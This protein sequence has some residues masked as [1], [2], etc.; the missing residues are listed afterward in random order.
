MGRAFVFEA[1]FD[2]A[3]RAGWVA[4][5]ATDAELAESMEATLLMR[6]R[7]TGRF[8]ESRVLVE[9][10]NRFAVLFVGRQDARIE[11]FLVAGLSFPGRVAYRV[12]AEESDLGGESTLAGERER[13]KAW[14]GA[15]PGEPVQLFREVP[16][17][18][19][20][21]HAA[22]EW[23]LSKDGDDVDGAYPL[24]AEP[25][26][27]LIDAD[28][29]VGRI[30]AVDEA[31][32][33][34]AEKSMS[35]RFELKDDAKQRLADFGAAHAARRCVAVVD[36]RVVD[37]RD[38]SASFFAEPY[39]VRAGWTFDEARSKMMAI[40]GGRLDA[41]LTFV[42]FSKRELP[43]VKRRGAE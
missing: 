28:I 16:R 25:S 41:P 42:E 32:E 6:L 11:E 13:L 19:G 14:T 29:P 17:D 43:H 8:V 40:S 20:G 12:V 7:R 18:A 27:P 26:F 15:H 22:L 34:A 2:F 5:D 36:D 38:D 3:R 9:G 24:L 4:P 33:G 37:V 30:F 35:L 39:G 1:D 21:P 23:T 31:E 10:D